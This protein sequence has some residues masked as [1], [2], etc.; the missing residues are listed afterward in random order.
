MFCYTHP[1]RETLLRCNRCDQP[2]CTACAVRTPTGYRC[3]ECVKGQQ[4][5]FETAQWWDYPVAAVS[6]GVLSY[7]GSLIVG[8][9]G[10]FTF[11]LSPVAGMVIA[12]VV[13]WLL[14][15]R[16][17]KN[18]PWIVA[19][20]TLI[21]GLASPVISLFFLMMLAPQGLLGGLLGV[22]WPALYAILAAST[23]YFRLKGIRL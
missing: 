2:M 17:S 4:K 18:L 9:L 21:G 1:Q 3:K 19:G 23:A 12:E 20:G 22:L 15:R 8:S 13:R 14:K 5:Y 11:F 7:I 16:R 10:F 6:A